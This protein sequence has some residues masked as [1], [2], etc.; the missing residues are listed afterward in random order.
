METTS[1][2]WISRPALASC[3]FTVTRPASQV[4]FAS[5][6]RRITRLH[7]KKRSRRIGS[8]WKG[9]CHHKGTKPQRSRAF[10]VALCLCGDTKSVF[11]DG[12]IG[13]FRSAGIHV[14]FGGP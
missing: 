14:P 5:V 13:F 7:F 3:P 1:P 11:R 4:S 6:R 12:F 9:G 2:A 10:F 8:T